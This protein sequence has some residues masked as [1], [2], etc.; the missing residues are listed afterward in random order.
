MGHP[1]RQF[2]HRQQAFDPVWQR[3]LNAEYSGTPATLG[4]IYHD[5]GLAG[6]VYPAIT[7]TSA[8][9]TPPQNIDGASGDLPFPVVEPFPDPVEPAFLLNE[10][11]ATIRLFVVMDPEQADAAALWVA[12]TWC[13]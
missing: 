13:F 2:T 6:W 5:A 10:L 12:L 11:A 1:R 3:F 4:T 9:V 8:S 7:A